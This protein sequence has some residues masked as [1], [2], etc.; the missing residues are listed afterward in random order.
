MKEPARLPG[1]KLN[2]KETRGR[3]RRP[4]VLA[5]M[6]DHPGVCTRRNDDDKP[7]AFEI[8]TDHPG[9]LAGN[10]LSRVGNGTALTSGSLGAYF[11]NTRQRTSVVQRS[12]CF[13]SAFVDNRSSPE[14]V[15]EG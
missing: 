3:R 4:C 8:R 1:R 13:G 6:Y 12:S 5:E 9:E 2:C 10:L 11:S 14:P 15:D 7:A